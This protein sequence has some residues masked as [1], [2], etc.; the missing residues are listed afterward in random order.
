[1]KLLHHLFD[2][3]TECHSL[4]VSMSVSNY[5]EY[6]DEPY[7][8]QGNIDG[9]RRALTT[10]TGKRIRKRMIS[11]LKEGAIVPPLV[12]GAMVDYQVF[13]EL[14]S[15][16]KQ[17]LSESFVVSSKRLVEV[18]EELKNNDIALSIIDGMQR[19]TAYIEAG[20]IVSDN[21]IRIEIWLTHK[22]ESLTYRM[23]VLN[24]GQS[25]W[26]LRRQLE[27]LFKPLIN[28][29]ESRLN[30]EYP[31]LLDK[32]SLTDI[33][34]GESRT[35]AGIYQKKQIIEAYIAF[36]LRKE[37][38]DN[39]TVLAD[40]FSKLDM[41]DSQTNSDF[42]KYFNTALKQLINIDHALT[43][44][45]LVESYEN[46]KYKV[47]KNIFD[48]HPARIGF[49]TGFSLEIFGSPGIELSQEKIL[50]KLENVNNRCNALITAINDAED[51]D[52]FLK[53]DIL[54]EAYKSMP[55]NK[56]GDSQREFFKN[57]FRQ[58]FKDDYEIKTMEPIW[59]AGR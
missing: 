3:K 16:L 52:D 28:S 48:G 51:K 46:E 23:L 1:M 25:P 50:L 35:A 14:D 36:S 56:L 37:K 31:T 15:L 6:I 22:V 47:G 2:R 8:D 49:F 27:V 30:E 7:K 11:D 42:I 59:R 43:N 24:T 26:N 18:L 45:L 12:I 5:L 53:L 44:C 34:S 4:L 55:V 38:V 41:V 54:N 32:F 58:F 40:E 29:I 21:E 13:K 19:T 9:Q 33:D 10:T 17:D 57:T 39:Q 20:S